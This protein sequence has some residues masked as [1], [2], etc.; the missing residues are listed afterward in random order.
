MSMNKFL[1]WREFL[2]SVLLVVFLGT[3]FYPPWNRTYQTTGISQVVKPGPRAFLFSPPEPA[4][5]DG[6]RPDAP[7]FGVAIA[8]DRLVLEWIVIGACALVLVRFRKRS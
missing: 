7:N 1:H 4:P 2:W 3:V 8:W 6:W 5:P